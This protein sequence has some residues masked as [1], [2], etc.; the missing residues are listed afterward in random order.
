LPKLARH[1]HGGLALQAWAN[2]EMEGLRDDDVWTTGLPLFHVG[3]ACCAVLTALHQGATNVLL[4]P[5]GYRNPNVVRNLWAL[6]QRFRVTVVGMVPTS[7]GAAL[8]VPVDGFDLSSL[9]LCFTGASTMP[10]ETSR[11]VERLL[12]LPVHEGWGMTELHGYGTMTPAQGEVKIGSA[13]LRAPYTEL[14]VGEVEG[15]RLART[16]P[17]GETGHVLA[18]GPML[19]AGYANEAHN[20]WIEGDDGGR[21]FDTG[22]L[23]RIDADGYVWLSG[24][25]K[26]VIIRGGHNI[27]PRAIEDAALQFP[28][29]ALAAAVGRPDA[30]AGEVPMLFVAPQPGATIDRDAL[31][32]FV[33][34]NIMEPPARPRAVSVIAEMPVTPV[35]KIFKPKLREIAAS[36]AARELLALEGLS[37]EVSVE[38][39]TDPSRGLYLSVTATPGTAETAERLLKKFPVKVELRP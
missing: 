16:L 23:G 7:W 13:G 6:V 9:R 26:D 4:T 18:R 12:G 36:E 35:G 21:W 20:A 29:V 3:G 14:I 28:G 8:N 39:V 1:T 34:D 27:D 10:A 15:G 33:Q 24:R 19:F 30:Y 37:G 11:G 5:A 25:A 17:A 38:A 2:A 31:A 22:D 32:A